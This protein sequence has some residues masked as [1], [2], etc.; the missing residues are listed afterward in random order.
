[1]TSETARTETPRPRSTSQN[2]HALIDR[3]VGA[4]DEDRASSNARRNGHVHD[5]VDLARA[6][7]AAARH[8]ALAKPGSF[9]STLSPVRST[10]AE[11]TTATSPPVRGVAAR[12]L[13]E[14]LAARK[15]RYLARE[16]GERRR[17]ALESGIE[18][19]V[20]MTGVHERK[21]NLE[22]EED[23]EDEREVGEDH[24][25]PHSARNLKPTRRTVSIRP[26]SPSFLRSEATWTSSVRVGPYQWGSQ[27]SSMICSRLTT[28][29]G[30]ARGARAGRTPSG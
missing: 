22:D 2:W 28:A 18:R 15:L 20:L 8:R 13:R 29:P 5:P 10:P 9:E 25:S 17:V 4:S 16:D 3:L 30:L 1:M 6:R 26:G 7:R 14:V 19:I 12:E 21:R 24:A 27:T 11:S 23:C